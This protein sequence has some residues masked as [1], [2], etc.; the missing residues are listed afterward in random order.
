MKLGIIIF[1][2]GL[3]ITVYLVN[4]KFKKIFFKRIVILFGILSIIY[5]LIL[6]VQPNNYIK[7]TKTTISK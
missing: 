4:L 5:G 3:S 6:I 7:F 2:L 1:I